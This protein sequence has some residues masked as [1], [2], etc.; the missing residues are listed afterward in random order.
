MTCQELR[1]EKI[2]A[3]MAENPFLLSRGVIR[4]LAGVEQRATILI[5]SSTAFP[6]FVKFESL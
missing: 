2:L 5:Y 6:K 1:S 3:L 4:V